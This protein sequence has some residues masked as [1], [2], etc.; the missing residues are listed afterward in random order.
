MPYKILLFDADGTLLDFKESERVGLQTVFEEKGIPFTEKMRSYY[1][2]MNVQ[3]WKDFE[4]GKFPKQHIFDVRFQQLLDAF[5][6][7]GNG[8]EFETAYRE[9]LNKGSHIIPHAIELC[10]T[11]AKHYRMYIITNGVSHTQYQRLHDSGLDAYFA[12]IF[13]SEDIGYQKPQKE[14]FDYVLQQIDGDKSEMLVIGDSLSSDILGANLSGIDSC[15]LNMEGAIN[16]TKANPTY[17]IERLTD[18][19]KLL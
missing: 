6:I 19:W 18:L 13:V 14:Y 9:Q 15:W 7:E 10:G 2:E 5:Q 3:L 8:N 4:L 1:L 16:D 11:L 12:G 17:E